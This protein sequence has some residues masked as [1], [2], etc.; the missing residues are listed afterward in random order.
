[1]VRSKDFKQ[2]VESIRTRR[3]AAWSGY[4]H[5]PPAFTALFF[6]FSSPPPRS[7]KLPIPVE[8]RKSLGNLRMAPYEGKGGLGWSGGGGGAE[9][10][11]ESVRRAGSSSFRPPI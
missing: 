3:R 7:Q 1:M 8:L 2:A 5:R 6:D 10:Q 4:H 11:C 9:A